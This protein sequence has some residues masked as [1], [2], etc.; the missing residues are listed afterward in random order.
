[1]QGPSNRIEPAPLWDAITPHNTNVLS[2]KY[3]AFYV[4]TAGDLA[5][6][7]SK[8]T[9]LATHAVVV[10]PLLIRPSIIMATGTTATIYGLYHD[11]IQ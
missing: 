11:E 1:M 5:C 4:T 2:R 9:A 6:K 8:G 3:S 7:D 10:G